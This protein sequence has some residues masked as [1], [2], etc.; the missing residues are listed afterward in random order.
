MPTTIPTDVDETGATIKWNNFLSN[1]F[2]PPERCC[3]QM[4][5]GQNVHLTNAPVHIQLLRGVVHLYRAL[6][7]KPSMISKKMKTPST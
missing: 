1:D 6:Q 5:Q 4:G 2:W 7:M 3:H